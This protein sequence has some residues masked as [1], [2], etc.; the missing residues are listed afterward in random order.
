MKKALAALREED[1]E[2]LFL[3]PAMITIL[4][5]GADDDVEQKE[6]EAAERITRYRK[7]VPRHAV[8]IPY[9]ED[10]HERIEKDIQHLLNEYPSLAE[11]RNPI[12][13]KQL[14]QL[15]RIFK[16]LD[17]E[18][19]TAFYQ[20]FI[21]LARHIAESAGGVLGFFSVSPEEKKWMELDMIHDPS[22]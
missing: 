19:A 9:Y 16:Q 14:E 15:N 13:A 12:I 6:L 18:T 8:L 5:A 20:S 10:V 4:I 22:K 1:R 7:S 2:F 17:K 21:S 3:A 11:L